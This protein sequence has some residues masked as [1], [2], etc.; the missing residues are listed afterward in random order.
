M[1]NND[2]GWIELNIPFGPCYI[3]NNFRETE[4]DSLVFR[5]LVKPGMLVRLK[6]GLEYLIGDVNLNRGVC[7]DCTAFDK[8]DIIVAY[9]IVWEKD[10]TVT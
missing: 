3:N 5:G 8:D 10:E 7:D 1:K 4:I 9:K 6:N 2:E